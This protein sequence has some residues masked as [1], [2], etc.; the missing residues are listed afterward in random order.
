MA[1]LPGDTVCP[2]C[3]SPNLHFSPK[4]QVQVCV[5]CCHE[6]SAGKPRPSRRIFL[7]YGHDEHA[8][9]AQRLKEDL[10]AQGHSVWFDLEKLKPGADW[11]KHIEEGL[12][13]A[14]EIPGA[15]RVV[16]LMTPHSVRRPDGY[17]L[18]EMARALQRRL[19]IVPVMVV[20]CEPPLSICRIQWLDMQ[21]C[22]PLL[23]GS[24]RYEGKFAVLTEVL[25]REA[26][27]FEGAHGRLANLLQPLPFEAD[28][29]PHVRRFTGRQ[30]VFD[31][32]DA[33][34]VDQ[35]ASR[36]FWILG[37]PGVGKTALAA[38]LCSHRREVAAFHL[39]R[40]GHVQKADPRR[41]VLSIAY[42][43]GSQLPDYFDRLQAVNLEQLIPESNAQTLFDELIVQPLARGFPEPDH[44]AVVLIDA[45]DEAT[46]GGRNE[47]AAFLATEFQKT[48]AWLR[49]IVTSRPDPAVAFHLQGLTPYVLDAAVPENEADIRAYLEREIERAVGRKPDPAV[50][51]RIISGS[52]GIFLYVEWIC[53]ELAMGRLSLDRLDDFPQGL[54][55][56]YAQFFTRQFPDIREYESDLLPAL[57]A[58]SASR[59]PLSIEY[60]SALVGWN[61]RAQMRFLR[62][63]GSLFCVEDGR[64][65]PFHR[66]LLEWLNAPDRA[67]P[68]YAGLIDG[69]RRLADRGWQEYRSGTHSLSEYALAHL[70]AHLREAR[71]WDELEAL[72]TDLRYIQ[73]RCAAGG[74]YDL[75]DDYRHVLD[76]L[77][78]AEASCKAEAARTVSIRDYTEKLISL[79]SVCRQSIECG[80]DSVT[81]APDS[82]PQPPEAL[83]PDADRTTTGVVQRVEKAPTRLGR[84]RSFAQFVNAES[85]TL[86]R[87]SSMRGFGVQQAYSSARSG[88]VADAAAAL[89]AGDET[90]NPA[91]LR[92]ESSRPE[93][94][95]QP[96]LLRTLTG[97]SD[98]VCSLGV[99]LDGTRV[100]SGG[101]DRTM[102]VWNTLNGSCL[103]SRGGFAGS[104]AV[105]A[106]TPDG[107]YAVTA[108]STDK[109]VRV[110]DL[111]TGEPRHLIHWSGSVI[112]S[113]A[114]TA[115][116]GLA[117]AGCTDG[118]VNLLELE[119][120]R[121]LP[122][123]QHGDR[124]SAVAV[125]PDG[126]RVLSGSFGHTIRVWD[127]ASR[128]FVCDLSGH[129]AEVLG[130]AVSHDGSMA[131]SAGADGTVRVWD[132][133]NG[134]CRHTLTDHGRQ[135]VYG[136]ALT[137]DGRLAIT[138]GSERT[139]RVWD[140]DRGRCLKVL[141]GHIETILA[142]S[143]SADGRL[144]VSAGRDGTLRLWDIH[145]GSST[146]FSP[147]HS[148][149][150]E[151]VALS[152]DARRAASGGRDMLVGIWDTESANLNA[153]L[154]GHAGTVFAVAFTQDASKVISASKDAMLRLWDATTGDCEGEFVGHRG[155]VS[156]IAVTPDG[157]SL[158]SGS[159]DRT[160]RWWDIVTGQSRAVVECPDGMI[161]SLALSPD[162]CV[163]FCGTDNG[164]VYSWRLEDG[165]PIAMLE[166][167]TGWV[168]SVVVSADGRQLASGGRDRSVRVWDVRTGQCRHTLQAGGDAAI[169]LALSAD[170]RYLACGNLDRTL[171][172]FDLGTGHCEALCAHPA[173]VAA[174]AWRGQVLAV[175]DRDGRVVFF[176]PRGL[177][178]SLPTVTASIAFDFSSGRWDD[179]VTVRCA[180]CLSR[181]ELPSDIATAI[182]G[183]VPATAGPHCPSL[184]L[185]LA[186]WQDPILA[187]SCPHCSRPLRLNPFIVDT[188]RSSS[189]AGSGKFSLE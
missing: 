89:L 53:R 63:V 80:T 88:P 132:L 67:G 14:S 7:S 172:V 176:E 120:G 10:V 158:V 159:W 16:L 51:R 41:A 38:R 49:L 47:L 34:L 166:G 180:W 97:H 112:H 65:R 144:G 35:T 24:T 157:R 3:A 137:P 45:L 18:N 29:L 179:A 136:A 44:M 149:W 79:A 58:I 184:D 68:Y 81:A 186:L 12:D 152:P 2:A 106:A 90:S 117:V 101:S 27:A 175:G 86:V 156:C 162:G 111:S 163:A 96:A 183:V 109:H 46:A 60:L 143:L 42:Q 98:W 131:V 139:V 148:H 134:S 19:A 118:S 8:S 150:V 164:N 168:E 1:A 170:A 94:Q 171:R 167:H 23:D 4:R 108:A 91:I 181:F 36:V 151:T 173:S 189:T 95:P 83:L 50:V 116:G 140:V 105:M 76:A 52:E 154:P 124:V 188:R 130:V 39:C 57:D 126:A 110:W 22:V 5:D 107:R 13:W 84:I 129:T 70:P 141:Y 147:R 25:D 178:L 113:L 73:A 6:F 85:H 59:E 9:V 78:E 54:G 93:H 11:E 15:G 43:L 177:Q 119:G 145:D 37:K 104:V 71:R 48:P 174:L 56:I 125:T 92:L 33:W 185:P 103:M 100:V 72:L 165:H 138:G 155:E 55:G 77:P 64:V 182:R 61:E 128:R 20:W 28:L 133:L 17:C 135:R 121:V 87:F 160:L 127:R 75:I 122:L 74:T 187:T 102:R 115:D 142:V 114:V 32:I 161:Y 40:Y 21:D 30:W 99:T 146:I 62:A 169:A 153:M 66:S 82:A 69:H 123:Y 26:P 31:R